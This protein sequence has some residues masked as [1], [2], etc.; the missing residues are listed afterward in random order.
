MPA[1]S[2]NPLVLLTEE[3]AAA[4]LALHMV[5][6]APMQ[7]RLLSTVTE[8]TCL[9]V[10]MAKLVAD[11][12]QKPAR[13]HMARLIAQKMPKVYPAPAVQLAQLLYMCRRYLDFQGQQIIN[14]H[15]PAVALGKANS[16]Q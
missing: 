3:S 2:S 5:G 4:K 1:T 9:N 10:F 11:T 12:P 15:R 8:G 13:A 7:P 14:T 6:I 16:V